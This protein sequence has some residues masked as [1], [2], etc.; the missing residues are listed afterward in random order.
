MEIDMKELIKQAANVIKESDVLL[1]TAGAGIGVDSGLPD[2]RGNEGFWRAY[3]ALQGYSFIDMADPAWFRKDPQR[4]WG[5][6]GHRLNLYRSTVPHQGFAML[7]G[8]FKSKT[9]SSFI[10]T[11]NV[12]GQFQKA[13][14]DPALI[15]E[16]HGS[17]HHVQGFTGSGV[18]ASTD[19]I[20][21]AI[22]HDKVRLVGEL[23]THPQIKGAIRPNILMFGDM[24]W[25]DR[26][27]EEQEQRFEWWL[28]ENQQVRI[29]IVEL[30]AGT[31]I[32]SV[33]YQGERVLSTHS[34]ST[35]IR[36]NPR[37]SQINNSVRDRGISI[38][39]GALE[40]LS[41]IN[42]QYQQLNDL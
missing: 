12:D 30:G 14:F 15:C 24:T 28:K 4:A 5:F 2:F 18:I 33:R 13:G 25:N 39:L 6:Y 23:P 37:E 32:P 42:A 29:A 21:M 27:T 1:V 26:R 41:L 19:G 8:W 34:G 40:A 10:F 9:F 31:T 38:P 3:P 17:I 11:S 35:L 36:I 20:D 7:L 22:D 16:C